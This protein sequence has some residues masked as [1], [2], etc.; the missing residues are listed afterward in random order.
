MNF[1]R[2]TVLSWL[3]HRGPVRLK[4]YIQFARALA[5]LSARTPVCVAPLLAALVLLMSPE[6]E[7]YARC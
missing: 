7:A 5:G 2:T 1:S 6:L 3:A 4:R